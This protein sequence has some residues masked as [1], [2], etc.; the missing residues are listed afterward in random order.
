MIHGA[1]DVKTIYLTENQLFILSLYI[2]SFLLC[3]AENTT[4][5]NVK[6]FQHKLHLASF[7]AGT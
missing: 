7:L 2:V 3:S 1:K 4:V 5:L 6:V